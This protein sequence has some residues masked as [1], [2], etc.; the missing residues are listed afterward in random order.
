MDALSCVGC[1][2]LAIRGGVGESSVSNER[3]HRQQHPNPRDSID[4]CEGRVGVADGHTQA[5]RPPRTGA[6]PGHNRICALARSPKA[7]RGAAPSET[8][9]SRSRYCCCCLT[10][11]TRRLQ[12][13]HA[14]RRKLDPITGLGS[15]ISTP[16]HDRADRLGRSRGRT[17]ASEEARPISIVRS[18][19]A[20]DRIRNPWRRRQPQEQP[21]PQPV[22][23]TPA[24]R[25]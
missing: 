18:S 8:L 22:D 25:S 2:A 15:L 23:P 5:P 3:G 21:R 14:P 24:M 13:Q 10:I 20:V 12:H 1:W 11:E 16:P 19:S 6:L 9:R 4:V 17:R 7:W